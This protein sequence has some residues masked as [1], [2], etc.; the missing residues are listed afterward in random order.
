MSLIEDVDGLPV[1]LLVHAQNA[2]VVQG[3]EVLRVG[4]DGL[5]IEGL[6]IPDIA[7]LLPPEP[8]L[9]KDVGIPGRVF[10][11]ETHRLTGDGIDFGTKRCRGKRKRHSLAPRPLPVLNR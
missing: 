2:Y 6:G 10:R 1:A 7:R 3:V 4:F 9:E 8:G 11:R 5:P